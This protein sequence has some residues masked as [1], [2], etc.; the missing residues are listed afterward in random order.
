MGQ[1]RRISQAMVIGS[2]EETRQIASTLIEESGFTVIEAETVAEAAEL[3]MRHARGLTFVFAEAADADEARELSRLIA[4]NWPWIRL[5]VSMDRSALDTTD[6]PASA[7]RL[8]RPWRPLDLLI[9]A[10]RAMH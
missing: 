6:L 9:E 7:G 5:I 4:T 3:L 8:R 10:E 2:R 1:A